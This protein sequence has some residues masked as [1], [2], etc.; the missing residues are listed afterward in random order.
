MRTI[1]K[2]ITLPSTE[3]VPLVQENQRL[4]EFQTAEVITVAAAHGAHDTYFS[5]LP[6]ILP[7]L[8]QNLSLSTTQAGWLTVFSQVPNLLQPAI[9]HLADRRN[10]KALVILA[11]TLSGALITM[12]GLAPSFGIA[13]LL[14]LLAGF[15]TA[16]FHSIAPAMVSARSGGKV[17]RGM[18]F[19]M[20]GGEFGFGLGPLLVVAVIGALTIKGLPWLMSLGMLSSV[21]LF[22]RLRQVSTVRHAQAEPSLP[23]REALKE[24]SG[25]MLPI[26]AIT[27]INGFLI[28]NVVNYLPTFMSREGAVFAV[29]GASLTVV[30][31]GGTLGVFLMGLFSDRLGQRNIALWGTLASAVFSLAFLLSRGWL[32]M[33]FLAGIGLSAF[34]SNPAFLAMIQNRFTKN[35]SLANGVYMSTSF[36]L[37]SLVVLIVGMLADQFG[38]RPV[39]VGSA[40]AVFLSVPL[41]FLLP[42]R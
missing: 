4:E 24:M 41:I 26:M 17:G 12:V 9:G 21:I 5:F 31:L 37:R 33:F 2:K 29:A 6:T 1:E 3:P 10:L 42:Q 18:G 34:I 25:L 27:F 28:A 8:I 19:F 15:S 36:I 16:G 40:L 14:L 32:Q 11:P 38:M 22:F 20:V 30:E 35:R 13:A 39:F 7:L 23:A